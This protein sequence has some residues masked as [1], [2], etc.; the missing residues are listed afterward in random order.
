MCLEF[1]S[2]QCLFERKAIFPNAELDKSG[3]SFPAKATVVSDP[4][5]LPAT[6]LKRELQG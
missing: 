1:A 2:K 3:A 5:S 4:Q 6:F